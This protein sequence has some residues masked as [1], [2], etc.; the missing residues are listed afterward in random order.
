MLTT[1]TDNAH[2]EMNGLF[3]PTR[4]KLPLGGCAS[5]VPG[6]VRAPRL[7]PLCLAVLLAILVFLAT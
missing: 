3:A 4:V 1:K 7:C 6:E 5:T 2:L